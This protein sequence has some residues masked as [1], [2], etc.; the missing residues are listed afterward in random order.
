MSSKTICETREGFLTAVIQ[1]KATD[2]VLIM[3]G[4]NTEDGDTTSSMILLS[5]KCWIIKEA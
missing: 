2:I 1:T 5:L 3:N 4:I